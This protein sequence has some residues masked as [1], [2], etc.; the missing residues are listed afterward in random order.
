MFFTSVDLELA[1]LG[2]AEFIL[3]NHAFDGPLKDKLGTTFPNLGWSLDGLATNVSRVTC[4]D[5]ILLLIAG[6]PGMLGID[7]ND[8][9]TGINVRSEDCLVL[10]TEKTGCLHGDFANDLVLGINN[11][12]SPFDVG[13]FC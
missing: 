2:G 11:V 12:P 8:E 3:G 13:W 9:V 6:E 5:L 10:A 7:D 4:V 1:H